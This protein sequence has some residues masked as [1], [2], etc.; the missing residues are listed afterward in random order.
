VL[1][2]RKKWIIV[3]FLPIFVFNDEGSRVFKLLSS[4]VLKSFETAIFSYQNCAR[5]ISGR[6]NIRALTKKP[7]STTILC[8]IIQLFHEHNT[9]MK[10][11]PVQSSRGI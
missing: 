9:G 5:G 4:A 10:R 7:E 2:A 1:F 8:T 6:K 11:H 3:L